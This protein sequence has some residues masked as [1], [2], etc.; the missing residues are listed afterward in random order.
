MKIIRQFCAIALVGTLA[1]CATQTES[2]KGV[3][4]STLDQKGRIA[5]SELAEISPTAK[6][7]APKANGILVFP[8]IVKAGFVVGG[9]TGDGVLYVN[10]QPLEYYDVS[11]L[12]FGFQA[13]GQAYSQVL[14]F[15]SPEVLE[16]FR[17]SNGF[18]VG[19]DGG[20]T[21]IDADVGTKI[22][23]SNLQNDIVAF[24]FGSSGL[25][26]GVALDGTKY[27]KKDL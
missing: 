20:V 21:V 5:L 19:V 14:M 18:E 2:Q 11:G 10:Q 26:G 24:V 3:E 6:A 22:N 9:E 13:G 17:S 4:R 15:M 27:T 25:A 8:Q 16:K 12:S 7:L 23:T 1:A